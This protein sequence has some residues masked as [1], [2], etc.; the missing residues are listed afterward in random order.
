METI[1]SKLDEYYDTSRS[2]ALWARHCYQMIRAG[3]GIIEVNT[4]EMID[5]SHR[6]IANNGKL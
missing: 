3:L 6:D 1:R 2:D 4:A 5:L